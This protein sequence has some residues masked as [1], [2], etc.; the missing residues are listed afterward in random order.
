MESCDPQGSTGLLDASAK[1]LPSHSPFS[2]CHR[3]WDAEPGNFGVVVNEA[4][5]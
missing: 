3:P 4:A 5:G 2:G 1:H